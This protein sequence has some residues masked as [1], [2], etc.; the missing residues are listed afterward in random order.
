MNYM[1]ISFIAFTNY[2]NS[3]IH[4]EKNIFIVQHRFKEILIRL[5]NIKVG[6]LTKYA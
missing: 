3:V 5:G 6:K 4:A 1:N 2:L